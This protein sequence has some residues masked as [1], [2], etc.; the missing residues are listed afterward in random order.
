MPNRP[1]DP[2]VPPEENECVVS[3][4]NAVGELLESGRDIDKIYI[5]SG[6]REGSIKKLIA[7]AR[8]MKL[9]LIE[10]DRA[11]LDRLCGHTRHQG[12]V[13]VAAERNYASIDE[14][15]ALAEERGEAPFLVVCD[16]MEDPH[17]LG[18]VIRSAECCGVHGIIIPKRRSV[19][20]TPTVAKS[21]AGAIEHMLIA[22]VTNIAE[23]LKEL[24]A[25]GIWVY[26]ADMDGTAYSETDFSGPLALVLGSEGFGISRLVKENCDFTVSVPLYGNVNSMNVSAAAAVLLCECARQRHTKKEG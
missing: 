14:M 4:R 8:E 2:P 15:F 25:R 10:L 9:P 19:G 17:N 23:T 6:E 1:A 16:G 26:A 7:V 3:G 21:S 18:A 22:K 13:A 12:I 11:K 5:Q 20:L 24:K